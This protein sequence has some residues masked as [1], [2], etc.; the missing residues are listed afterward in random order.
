MTNRQPKGQTNGGEF[1]P[2]KNPEGTVVLDDT[3]YR[4]TR[5]DDL[6]EGDLVDLEGD[7]FA[8]PDGNSQFEYEYQRVSSVERE[9]DECTVVYFDDAVVGFPTDHQ[10][11]VVVEDTPAAPATAPET[12][13]RREF[14]I[15]GPRYYF[16][17]TDHDND[18]VD[19]VGAN[20][21][22]GG[23]WDV[24]YDRLTR[25]AT[26]TGRDAPPGLD[27][28]LAAEYRD[29]GQVD[30]R[31][32][33]A[34]LEPNAVLVTLNGQTYHVDGRQSHPLSD[35]TLRG[36]NSGQ[37][38]LLGRERPIGGAYI[39]GWTGSVEEI[40]KWVDES[41]AEFDRHDVEH[42]ETV[43]EFAAPARRYLEGVALAAEMGVLAARASA[44]AWLKERGLSS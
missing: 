28:E 15:D 19:Y 34:I 38:M 13:W 17:R 42:P 10:L 12:W 26:I 25:R 30:A 8:D 37:E 32:V 24:T 27:G 9:T 33:V 41:L 7:T 18:T 5:L 39:K 35:D 36:L 16:E 40:A 29:K 22:Y 20:L 4:P 31:S 43:G 6:K 14:E 11:K 3:T 21:R 44:P 2:G 23:G 1:A